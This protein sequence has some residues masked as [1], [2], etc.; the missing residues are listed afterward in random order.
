ML[1]N[2]WCGSN[3]MAWLVCRVLVMISTGTMQKRCWWDSHTIHYTV[4]WEQNIGPKQHFP[5]EMKTTCRL[6]DQLSEEYL[7]VCDRQLLSKGVSSWPWLVWDGPI[8]DV[9]YK[10]DGQQVLLLFEANLELHDQYLS[11]PQKRESSALWPL[12]STIAITYWQGGTQ[13]PPG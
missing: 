13:T 4:P 10:A 1:C 12:R 5:Q 7:E 6:S 3:C 2:I 9:P 11:K 8:D